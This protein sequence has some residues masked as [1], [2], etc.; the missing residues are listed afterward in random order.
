MA[1]NTTI[2]PTG[3]KTEGLRLAGTPPSPR[4]GGSDGAAVR[5]G[6]TNSHS[7]ERTTPQRSYRSRALDL[8]RN[9]PILSFAQSPLTSRAVKLSKHGANLYRALS[10]FTPPRNAIANHMRQTP[11]WT[12]YGVSTLPIKGR[13]LR[14]FGIHTTAVRMTRIGFQT[15]SGRP[16]SASS[17]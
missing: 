10:P 14:P 8:A 15:P 11:S 9:S 3:T 5:G 7:D 16:E 1:L 4:G 12:P 2:P 13:D 17:L 6:V